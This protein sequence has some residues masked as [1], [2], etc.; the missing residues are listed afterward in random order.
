MKRF[1]LMTAACLTLM[2][3]TSSCR[4]VYETF[5][6]VEDC[7]EWYLDKIYEAAMDGDEAKCEEYTQYMS[8]WM[9]G[10]DG[11]ELIEAARAA[12]EWLEDNPHAEGFMDY[13]ED[14]YDYDE[15]Y[16]YYW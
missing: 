12:G 13:F 2:F 4:W 6:S 5:M 10:L 14:L 15:L 1:I 8:E 11:S 16:D 9:E 3:A 7:T